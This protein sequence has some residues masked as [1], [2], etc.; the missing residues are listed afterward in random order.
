MKCYVRY[1]AT[2]IT[3]CRLSNQ[4]QIIE[5][6]VNPTPNATNLHFIRCDLLQDAHVSQ[7]LS[8]PQLEYLAGLSNETHI[9]TV[10]D[11]ICIPRVVGTK[12]HQAVRK[13][14]RN[15]LTRLGWKV[16]I[17]SFRDKTPNFGTL[18]FHN[19]VATLNP[20]AE[21]FLVLACH[22]D[23]KYYKDYDFVGEYTTNVQCS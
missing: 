22:Y 19:V 16:E 10:L 20:N 21:R 7:R 8:A 11:N 12:N 23:S 14:I 9:N 6:R 15:E 13:Y 2:L 18:T 5:S 3:L 17:D 4:L 1:L